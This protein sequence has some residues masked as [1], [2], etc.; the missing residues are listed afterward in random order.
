MVWYKGTRPLKRIVTMLGVVVV[1]LAASLLAGSAE[2]ETS[3]PTGFADLPWGTPAGAALLVAHMERHC[4]GYAGYEKYGLCP[5]YEL[6]GVDVRAS[7]ILLFDP[8]RALGGYFA[9]VESLGFQGLRSAVVGW[10]GPAHGER[11]VT[12][13]TGDGSPVTGQAMSWEWKRVRASLTERCTKTTHSCVLV[14]IDAMADHP[15]DA[16]VARTEPKP[17]RPGSRPAQGPRRPR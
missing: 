16:L 4:A 1:W 2:A 10:L 15:I 11:T 6:P 9:I 13:Q 17:F 5:S 3:E 7:V 12:Y 8:H 14:G